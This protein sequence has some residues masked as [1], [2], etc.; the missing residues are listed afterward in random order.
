MHGVHL[1]ARLVGEACLDPGRLRILDPGPRLLDRWRSFTAETGMSHLRSPGVHHLDLEPFSL[2]KFAGNRRTRR[3]GV[4]RGIY[5]RPS[6]ELFNEH[7]ELVIERFGLGE[8]HLR[9]HA[10]RLE[11]GPDGVRVTTHSG[12]ELHV[13]QVVLAIGAS[14]QPEWPSW[15]PK[16]DPRVRHIFGYGPAAEAFEEERLAPDVAPEH[17]RL[18][19]VGGGI[20]AA[21]L[22]LRLAVK[23]RR[24]D[25]VARHPLRV[26]DFDSDPGWLGPKLMPVFR[27]ESCPRGRR[28]LIHEA[29]YR[30]SVT[31]E[32]RRALRSAS[33][34][35]RLQVHE[36]AVS[37]LHLGDSDLRL[38][39]TSGRE[40]EADVLYL[41]TGF[42]GA[43]PGGAML[44]RLVE[45]FEL[46]CAPCGYPL[47]DSL[48]RWH[49][50][51]HVSGPL[52]ELELGPTA[53]NIAGARRAGDRLVEA[54]STLQVAA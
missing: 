47:V 10:S 30:G 49:E 53:R 37:N 24:V 42:A 2:I 34:S 19:V 50:R 18:I 5:N 14:G 27:R 15:A 48:L 21:Q 35:G 51:I 12:A 25:L 13:G 28:R 1:A 3:P 11:P 17:R 22:A 20:S 6:L 40:L 36:D 43:R 41:A 8:L 33:S 39:L 38:E 4:L 9:D 7:C 45:D 54:L 31:P 23:D 16:N 46:P 52:A 29:R 32:V 44:D 26:H